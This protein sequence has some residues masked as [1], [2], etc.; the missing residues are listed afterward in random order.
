MTATKL[1]AFSQKLGASPAIPMS[2]PAIAGPRIRA[3]LN[4]AL[5]RAMAL[6]RAARPTRSGM[7]DWNAGPAR[8]LAIPARPARTSTCQNRIESVWT[9]TARIPAKIARPTWVISRRRRW[10][11]LSARAP[12]YRVRTRAGAL[13]MNEASPSNPAD[14]VRRRTSQ[15]SAVICI[16]VPIFE[17]NVPA[18]KIR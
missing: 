18:R 2:T 12:A 5:L 9:R 11:M 8:A 15:P 1:A 16:H 17:M 14:P 3:R 4:W 6:P 13:P 7:I 10:S